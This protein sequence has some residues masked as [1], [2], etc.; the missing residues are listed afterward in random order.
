[1]SEEQTDYKQL[2][3]QLQADLSARK[4]KSTYEK[5]RQRLISEGYSEEQA[6]KYSEQITGDTDDEIKES[7]SKLTLDI[8]P[9]K[10]YAEPS[11]INGTRTKA[12]PKDKAEK[13]REAVRRLREK[14]KLRRK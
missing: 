7:V 4:A 8:P 14:G 1:M 9:K 12:K 5:K 13:G 2:Y 11:I 6:N 10:K 3:E